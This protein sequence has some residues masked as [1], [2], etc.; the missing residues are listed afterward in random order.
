MKKNVS[1]LILRVLGIAVTAILIAVLLCN[2]YVIVVRSVT[3]NPQPAI[4]GWSCSVV[5]S[6]SMES[7][8]SYN[9]VVVVKAQKDYYINEIVSFDDLDKDGNGK[10]SVVTHRIIEDNGDYFVT[11][12]DANN[13]EDDP[14]KKE[15]IIG[16]VVLVIPWVGWLIDA[17]K[18]PIGMA[19]LMVVGVG[20][21]VWPYIVD[22]FGEKKEE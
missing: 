13:T 20:L 4:F 22:K 21:L 5:K 1:R 10:K 2:V 18:S 8:I 19:I 14:I 12:G 15:Q 7:E 11:K 16:E 17:F 6:G 3:D 9:D